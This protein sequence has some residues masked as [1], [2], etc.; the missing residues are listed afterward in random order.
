M[1][2]LLG[3]FLIKFG[4]PTT[5]ALAFWGGKN[6]DARIMVNMSEQALTERHSPVLTVLLFNHVLINSKLKPFV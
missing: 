3:V 4:Y 5:K 2:V 1:D 6:L